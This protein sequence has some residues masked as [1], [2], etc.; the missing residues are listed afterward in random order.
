LRTNEE[1]TKEVDYGAEDV[2]LTLQGGFFA[3]H[4]KAPQQMGGRPALSVE[5]LVRAPESES[6]VEGSQSKIVFLGP[7]SS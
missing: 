7:T 2:R 6:A 5:N 4:K 1:I 3:I